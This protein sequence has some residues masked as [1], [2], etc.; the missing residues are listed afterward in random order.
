[1]I[2]WLFIGQANDYVSEYSSTAT[3]WELG[4]YTGE[5]VWGRDTEKFDS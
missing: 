2:I 4:L 5:M 1:M 3:R